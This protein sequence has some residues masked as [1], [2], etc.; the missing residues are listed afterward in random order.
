[1]RLVIVLWLVGCGRIG[2]DDVSR[3]A[4]DGAADGDGAP[5]VDCWSA[6][7]SGSPSLSSPERLGVSTTD[8]DANASLTA[9]GLTLF[10][11]HGPDG[12]HDLVVATRATRNL[13]F[14]AVMPLSSLNS[15]SEE[16]RLTVTDDGLL[17]VMASTR[18][19]SF[20][21]YQT[22]RTA[23]TMAFGAPDNSVFAAINS[24]G[25]NEFD[26][27][28]TS[29]GLRLYF[30]RTTTGGQDLFVADRA[31]RSAAFSAPVRL[32]GLGSFSARAD[33]TLSPDE[34][35]IAFSASNGN[36]LRLFF[37]VRANRDAAFGDAI[38]LSSITSAGVDADP[39]LSSDGCE[40][41]FSSNRTGD[42][43]LWRTTVTP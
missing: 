20:D 12:N 1:M 40:L 41:L 18:L 16:S 17:G 10:F 29:D 13:P 7:R 23:P 32:T 8:P 22:E 6:W 38:P 2:F 27:E 21:L 5:G 15:G 14:D 25:G 28:L 19:G 31:T 43:D 33:L 3:P 39:E 24:G 37:G 26:P 35:V 11:D 42:R 34:L 36:P 9:D 30:S 4:G